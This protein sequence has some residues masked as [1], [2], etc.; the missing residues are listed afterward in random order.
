MHSFAAAKVISYNITPLDRATPPFMLINY[1][2]GQC[3]LTQLEW[4]AVQEEG[5]SME[6]S[7]RDELF[8]FSVFGCAGTGNMQNV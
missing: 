3:S 6:A 1:A 2:V 5:R 7:G 4:E 8:S